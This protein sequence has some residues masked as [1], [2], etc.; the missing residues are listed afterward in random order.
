MQLFE[1]VAENRDASIILAQ[2]LG[3]VMLVMGDDFSAFLD[4]ILSF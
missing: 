2:A 1:K 4:A 3:G